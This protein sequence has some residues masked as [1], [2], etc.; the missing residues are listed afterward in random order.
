MG[1]LYDWK[2]GNRLGL[3]IIVCRE[4]FAQCY[5]CSHN[6]L[7]ACCKEIRPCDIK[8]ETHNQ[9][10]V[11]NYRIAIISNDRDFNKDI[12]AICKSKGINYIYYSLKPL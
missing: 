7:D 9:T 11:F 2:L 1:P 10:P 3:S 4:C 6:L 5:G 8:M 12:E